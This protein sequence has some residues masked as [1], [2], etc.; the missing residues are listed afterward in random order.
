M[1]KSKL[2]ILYDRLIQEDYWP[3]Q[4]YHIISLHEFCEQTNQMEKF[5]DFMNKISRDY[6]SETISELVLCVKEDIPYDL[7]LDDYVDIRVIKEI[8][9]FLKT[10]QGERYYKL[11]KRMIYDRWLS[12]W[13]R[14]FNNFTKTQ[15]PIDIDELELLYS[16]IQKNKV[17]HWLIINLFVSVYQKTSI[18]VLWELLL[19]EETIKFVENYNK[20]ECSTEGDHIILDFYEYCKKICNI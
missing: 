13:I 16:Y 1:E 18:E 6:E 11:A 5:N 17:N 10:N 19:N 7:F 14:E 15:N 2:K 12:S 3:V 8:K 4:I 20:N 9:N